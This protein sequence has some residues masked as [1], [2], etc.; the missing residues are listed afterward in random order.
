MCRGSIDR[1]LMDEGAINRAPTDNMNQLIT[2]PFTERFLDHVAAY[3]E[4][5]YIVPGKDMRRLAVVFGGHRPSLF[6]KRMLA[7]QIKGPFIPPR[8]LTMDELV[9][10]I[11]D[12]QAGSGKDV[13]DLE[14]S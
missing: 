2:I 1:T 3:I 13:S 7:D 12:G 9:T 4:R 8:F 10:M 5:E 6:L 11:T 14:H